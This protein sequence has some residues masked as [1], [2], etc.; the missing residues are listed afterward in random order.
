LPILVLEWQ[1]RHFLIDGLN[2][3]NRRVRNGEPG[4]HEVIVI[5]GRTP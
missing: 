2:R 3:V 4:P 5:H 1:G